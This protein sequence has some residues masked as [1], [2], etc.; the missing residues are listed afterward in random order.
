M[1]IDLHHYEELHDRPRQHAAR[2][3]ALWRQIGERFAQAPASVSFE[4]INEPHDK[5]DAG[6]LLAVIGPAL[7][8]VRK[9][10]PTRIVVIDGPEWAGLDAMLES[11][12]PDDPYAVPTFHYY[13]PVNF[14]FPEADWLEPESRDDFGRPRTWR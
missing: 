3:A 12:F 8:E 10:N 13:S 9:S 5:F 7:A 14:G 1:I 6:N 4:L 11:P 2:F